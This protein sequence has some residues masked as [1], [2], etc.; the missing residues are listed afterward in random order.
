[1]KSESAGS[2]SLPYGDLN[3]SVT[4]FSVTFQYELSNTIYIHYLHKLTV[5]LS[6]TKRAFSAR[7]DP[8]QYFLFSKKIAALRAA[9]SDLY[10][11][12]LSLPFRNS[13]QIEKLCRCNSSPIQFRRCGR[14]RR[15]LAY[16]GRCWTQCCQDV[17]GTN[18][19]DQI[20]GTKRCEYQDVHDP[21]PFPQLLPVHN[22]AQT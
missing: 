14:I 19:E 22:Y 15:D 2:P 5:F 20:P 13:F 6:D 9:T 17:F 7:L 11:Y 21:L 12:F 16:C 3:S 4:R 8:M 1:M 18:L 10:N